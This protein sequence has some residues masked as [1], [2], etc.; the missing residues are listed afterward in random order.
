MKPWLILACAIA[1]ASCVSV[2]D[3]KRE[4]AATACNSFS[5][6]YAAASRTPLGSPTDT[7]KI[8]EAAH[9]YTN[10]YSYDGEI[11]WVSKNEVL[12]ASTGVLLR[13]RRDTEHPWKVIEA[14]EY[15][16]VG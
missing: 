9:R 12:V 1:T 4:S 11:R 7:V 2:I 16:T 15:V 14:V 6:Y 5:G 10:D 3:S 8:T 13:L